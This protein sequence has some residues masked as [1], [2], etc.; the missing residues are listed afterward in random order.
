MLMFQAPST[1]PGRTRWA[2]RWWRARPLRKPGTRA[3]LLLS[4]VAVASLLSSACVKDEHP[5]ANGSS[6]VSCHEQDRL[7]PTL[8]SHTADG[9]P[10][11]C[12]GCHSTDGWKPADFDHQALFPIA[13]GP[14]ALSCASCHLDTANTASFSCTHC[15]E[16]EQAKM[17]DTH[18][19]ERNY[20]WESAACF[21]CHP[22]GRS[23]ED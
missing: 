16:H 8:P 15:H 1:Q 18:Q 3:R 10:T 21:G 19:E 11:D 14:H 13:S 12:A 22:Q 17:A 6:C 9:F 4:G 7:V 5:A 2:E 23:A 20:S